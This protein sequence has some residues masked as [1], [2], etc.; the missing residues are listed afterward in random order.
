MTA[1]S[2]E[3][4]GERLAQP[5]GGGVGIHRQEADDVLTGDVRGVDARVRADEAVA[6]L[7]D[8]DAAVH[9]ND[10]AALPQD[11]LDLARVLAVA[12]GRSFGQG[13]GL[14]RSQV[15]QTPFGLAHDLVGHD[16]Y[17]PRARSSPTAPAMQAR[18]VVARPD[19][20][21]APYRAAPRCRSRPPDLRLFELREVRRGVQVEGQV[22]TAR[23]A[24]RPGRA[25]GPLAGG[26]RSSRCRRRRPARRADAAGARWCPCGRGPGRSS[27]KEEPPRPEH[28]SHV[29][30]V[31]QRQI[32]REG[33]AGP[34]L[35]AP[36]PSARASSRAGFRPPLCCLSGV[37]PRPCASASTIG[38][39]L[40]TPTPSDP[41]ARRARRPRA[42]H[43]Q[44]EPGP[45]AGVQD[46]GEPALGAAQVFDRHDR[47]DVRCPA[48]A[49]ASSAPNPTTSR[50]QARPVGSSRMIA[51]V[52]STRIP[53]ASIAARCALVHPVHDHAVHEPRV[54]PG[55]AGG[56][57]LVA[58]GRQHPVRRPLE[59]PTSDDGADRD[60]R[61]RARSAAPCSS[62]A[63]PGSDRCSRSGW[64]GRRRRGRPRP[65]RRGPRR[66]VARPRCPAA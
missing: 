64:R 33:R 10:P 21:H 8:D 20:R 37:A 42:H 54:H 19:L 12:G 58:E 26:P 24:G 22:G 31:E 18:Q 66:S 56:R 50:G 25:R 61:A 14:D 63:R 7:G 3:P 30:R 40:T 28:R 41:G 55:D 2:E 59:R 34:R 44:G 43:V 16:D 1:T 46:R 27:R 9:A 60:L 13:G 53:R 23:R 15:D 62:R 57:D 11:D 52:A 35:P 32:G 6:R 45:G 4:G 39:G 48:Q 49:A 65:A 36:R 5:R 38:S 29:R 17:V 51:S 47:E